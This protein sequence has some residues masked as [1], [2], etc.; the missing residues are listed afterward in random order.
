MPVQA[1]SLEAYRQLR[2]TLPV[3]H[4]RVVAGL[5]AFYRR[6]HQWPTA[7]ELYDHMKR[8]GT[9]SDLNDVRPRLTELREKRVVDNP[10]EKRRCHMTTKRAFLWRLVDEPRLF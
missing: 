4:A 9:A 7:Y 5:E 8:E 6:H 10:S 3:H 1:T 2:T